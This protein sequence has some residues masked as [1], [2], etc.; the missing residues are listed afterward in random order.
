[1]FIEIESLFHL[2]L[3]YFRQ[4]WSYIEVGIISCSWSSV[5]IYIWKYEEGKRIG[6]LFA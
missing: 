1:M 6:D 2:K 4:F 5:G 3:S